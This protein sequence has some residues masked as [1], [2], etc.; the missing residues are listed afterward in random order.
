MMPFALFF[1][2]VLVTTA[3][4]VYLPQLHGLEQMHPFILPV[5]PLLFLPSAFL[6]PSIPSPST[7]PFLSLSLPLILSPLPPLLLSLP[8]PPNPDLGSL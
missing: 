5:T 3:G 6:S 4:G 1:C 8:F 7:S 2:V